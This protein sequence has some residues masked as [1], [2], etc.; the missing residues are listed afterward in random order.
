MQLQ[1]EKFKT[2]LTISAL[3]RSQ[4]CN[5]RGELSE[6]CASTCTLSQLHVHACRPE[7]ASTEVARAN[8]IEPLQE[9]VATYI[10][11]YTYINT[12]T[13]KYN[14]SIQIV[15]T[16]S[17]TCFIPRLDVRRQLG[18]CERNNK[19]HQQNLRLGPHTRASAASGEGHTVP[20]RV[21]PRG[22]D[23]AASLVLVCRPGGLTA[24]TAPP[25]KKMLFSSCFPS[26]I[27]T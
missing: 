14:F 1:K 10:C 24:W 7:L 6:S 12:N 13:C 4:H 11:L 16:E 22:T 5:L 26:N 17:S 21:Q 27:A 9:H 19:V 25:T 2:T 15:F 3:L 8:Q 20:E 18:I 23:N